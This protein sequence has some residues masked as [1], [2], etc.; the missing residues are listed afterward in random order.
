MALL[1]TRWLVTCT[2]REMLPAKL[3]LI[4]IIAM[5][6]LF[7]LFQVRIDKNIP[8]STWVKKRE[9]IANGICKLGAG[10]RD[11]QILRDGWVRY[12][13][14]K[15]AAGGAGHRTRQV[16]TGKRERG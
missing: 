16:E 6:C 14:Q 8:E 13:S 2:D 3:L 11:R 4:A 1:V 15:N 12:L 9:D 7:S 5:M 10:Y